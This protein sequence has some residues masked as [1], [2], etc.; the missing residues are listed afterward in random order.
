MHNIVFLAKINNIETHTGYISKS[1]LTARTTEKIALNA[2]PDLATFV[3][4][5]HLLLIKTALYG[6]KIYGARFHS[7]LSYALTD[8]GFVPSMGVCD[9]WMR[10]EVYYYSYVTCYWNNTIVIHKYPE[11]V[12]DSIIGKGFTIK[13]TSDPDY[14]LGGYFNRVKDP[15]TDNKILT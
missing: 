3:H 11:H 14:F 2:G 13:E 7:Q 9:I 15:N 4:Y 10:N 12:F 5:G 6:L 1:Y 8:L